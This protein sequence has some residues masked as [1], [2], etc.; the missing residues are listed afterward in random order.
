M[1]KKRNNKGF[2]LAEILAV[3]LVLMIIFTVLYSNFMPL[4]G[5]YVRAESYNDI[6]SQYELHY[7]RKLFKSYSQDEN[8]LGNENYIVL[9]SNEI[10]ECSTS[11]NEAVCNSLKDEL[12]PTLILTKYNLLELKNYI[13]Q[14]TYQQDD[15]NKKEAL[16]ELKNYILSLPDYADRDGEEEVYRLIIKTNTGY[17][18][19]KLAYTV[20]KTSAN[21]PELL[22]NMIPVYY[23]EDNN[24]WKKADSTNKSSFYKW[25]DYDK[26]MWA[27]AVT[28][29]STNRD[30][31]LKADVGTEI[32]MND[33]NTMWVWIPRFK[34]TYFSSSS[35]ELINVEFERGLSSTG[36]ISCTDNVSSSGNTSETCTDTT[37]GSLIT[38]TSTYTHPAFTFGDEELTGIWVGKFENSSLEA[39]V[40]NYLNKASDSTIIIKP[41]VQS[42]RYKLLSYQFKDVRQME[43]ANNIYG[44]EQNSSTTFNW[45]GVL[46]GDNNNTLDTHMMKN[47][48]WGAV[49]YLS[50]SEYGVGR[51]I[52]TNN[53]GK[54]YTGRSGGNVGG[55]TAANTVY[56]NQTSTAQYNDYGY[57]TYDGYLLSYGTNTKTTTRDMSK[58]ASTTGNI[59]GIYDM[60]GG[61]DEH[62]MANMI[63][64]DGKFYASSAGNWSTTI[65]PDAK[66]YDSYTYST[67]NTTYT[68]GKL[69]DATIEMNPNSEKSWYNDIARFMASSSTNY[70][71]FLRGNRGSFYESYPGIGAFY[72]HYSQ[73]CGFDYG[74]SRSV[75]SIY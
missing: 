41:D 23:D 25:Y 63:G 65:Y 27:N 58:V 7:F 50:H 4:S 21:A 46:T 62:V 32:S 60:S 54:Y 40:E 73:G 6:S 10:N 30:T 16:D 28:V 38:G 31:Y 14:N 9:L 67:S 48:E 70:V 11:S 8:T 15:E 75:L 71:W 37:N 68:R 36:T 47:M 22:S 13:K 33:I 5:E 17:A 19:T 61:A 18:T 3:T 56:T 39:I 69:G 45:N 2:A 64:S 66:Y 42:L 59:Y 20:A 51:E 53:S 52:Y 34:Y 44:F 35:P 72:F 24:V 12:N 43:Q 49:V 29:T 1:K 55:S 74:A 57:Y 26:K